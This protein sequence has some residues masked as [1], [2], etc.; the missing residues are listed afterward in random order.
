MELIQ[1]KI[2]N[3]IQ[4]HSTPTSKTPTYDFLP[5]VELAGRE[6]NMRW[7]GGGVLHGG[8]REFILAVVTNVW[9]V[10]IFRNWVMTIGVYRPL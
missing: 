2:S 1:P 4:S 6:V 3:C 8:S 5:L 7:W 10:D 9:A